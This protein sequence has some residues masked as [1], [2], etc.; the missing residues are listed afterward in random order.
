MNGKL[1]GFKIFWRVKE[2]GRS[3]ERYWNKAFSPPQ[4]WKRQLT[5][6]Y[7]ENECN[8][9]MSSNVQMLTDSV[10]LWHGPLLLKLRTDSVWQNKKD[11]IFFLMTP[12][13]IYWAS[14]VAQRVM[15]LPAIQGTWVWSLA[16]EDLWR[17]EWLP[18]PVFQYWKTPRT[19]EPD[20]LQFMASQIVRHNWV[21]KQRTTH[22]SVTKLG[23]WYISFF[24]F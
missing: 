16:W 22:V 2:E 14:P 24:F 15:N 3:L 1:L 9:Q 8:V 20:R 5:F 18:I 21:T 4:S 23:I 10:A 7:D 19:E 6:I 11:L 17:R 13:N 12:W